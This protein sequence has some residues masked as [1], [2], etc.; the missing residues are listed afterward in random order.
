MYLLAAIYHEIVVKLHTSS[1]LVLFT[2]QDHTMYVKL[3]FLY[4]HIYAGHFEYATV[5]IRS[6]FYK[7]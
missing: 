2:S 1:N 4:K 7:L 3:I 5:I 6:V